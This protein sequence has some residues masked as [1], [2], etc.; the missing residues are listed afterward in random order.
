M[1]AQIEKFVLFCLFKKELLFVF[2][3]FYDY[4]QA[5]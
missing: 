4:K 5:L 2:M 3:Y 1:K